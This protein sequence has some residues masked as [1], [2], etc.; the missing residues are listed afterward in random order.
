MVIQVQG[1]LIIVG[2][3]LRVG[4]ISTETPPEAPPV[5]LPNDY[6]FITE[7][8]TESANWGLITEGV[9]DTLDYG[10]IV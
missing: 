5:G 9:D 10:T 3:E 1:R 8:I 7:N 2:G 4:P 6:R